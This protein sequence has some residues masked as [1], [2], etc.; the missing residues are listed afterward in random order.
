MKLA[1]L[2]PSFVVPL[3]LLGGS[4][5]AA[6]GD[7]RLIRGANT[8]IDPTDDV[9]VC[10]QDVWFHQ[11]D[12]KVGNLAD[13]FATFNTTKPTASFTTG[14]GAGFVANEFT[15]YAFNQDDPTHTA[16]FEGTYTG[17]IDNLAAEVYLFTP[18]AAG[19]TQ[20]GFLTTLNVDGNMLY[21]SD[22]VAGDAANLS[23]GG[24]AA[25]KFQFA[26]TNVY[27][28]L[29]ANGMNGDGPHS[30]QLGISPYF[31]GDDSVYVYDAAEVPSGMIFN[32]EKSGLSSYSEIQ[33]QVE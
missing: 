9:S 13:G 32:L 8:P 23:S 11:S 33:L 4:A 27:E 26:F 5:L 6:N 21:Q 10:R 18:A 15:Q 12:S 29:E 31:I 14:A 19:V 7:C 17:N 20:Y 28:V 22:F 16:W 2:I 1:R 25:S 30:V 3:V 24:Q